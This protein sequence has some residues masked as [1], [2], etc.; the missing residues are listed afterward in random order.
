MTL[1]HFDKWNM[2]NKT[3]SLP[4]PCPDKK[5]KKKKAKQMQWMQLLHT[6]VVTLSLM[7]LFTRRFKVREGKA[8]HTFGPHVRAGPSDGARAE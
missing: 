7:P 4:P 2:K 5:R 3:T 8:A 6:D 1:M